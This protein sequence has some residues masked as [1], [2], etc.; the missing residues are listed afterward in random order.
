M[1]AERLFFALW[2]PADVRAALVT[3]R[4]ALPA[5]P[6]RLSHALDLHLTLVFIGAV[7]DALRPCI[8]SAAED[9][10]ADPFE[11]RLDAVGDWPRS[12]I[13]FAR[14][15]ETPPMLF[16]LVSQL[17]HHCLVCGLQQERR[18]YRP[19]VTLARKAP[20]LMPHAIDISWP[21]ADFVLAASKAGRT[22]SYQILRSW[23]L[24]V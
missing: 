7:D 23:P 6:G 5:R 17:E 3:E 2:P 1:S 22:P 16:N 24:G 8:E 20:P 15:T 9:V 13:W 12:R 14:P 18:P 11:L 19:H 21:V 10:I 4:A